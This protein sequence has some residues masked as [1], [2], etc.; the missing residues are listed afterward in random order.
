MSSAE[1]LIEAQ[2][3]SAFQVLV[4]QPDALFEALP[5]A[6]CLHAS[7]GAVVRF[8][9]KAAELWGRELRVGQKL[10][11]FCGSR[12]MSVRADKSAP[13]ERDALTH[14]LRTGQP[15][16]GGEIALERPDGYR[17]TC[18][19]DVQALKSAAGRIEGAL[20]CYRDSGIRK[21][22]ATAP[23]DELGRR[24]ERDLAQ[25]IAQQSALYEFTDRL[26]RSR[27]LDEVY[28]AALEAILRALG[29]DRASILLFDDAGVMRFVASRGL[30]ETY[31]RAVEGHS[32]WIPESTDPQPIVVADISETSEPESLKAVVRQEGIAGLS[33]IPLTAGGKLIGKFMTYYNGGHDFDDAE[34]TLA[35]I[36]ARQIGLNV[37]RVRAEE[38]RRVSEEALLRERELFQTIIDRIPVMISVYEPGGRLLQLN[39]EFERLVGWRIEDLPPGGSLMEAIYPDPKYRA[40]VMDFMNSCRDGWMDMEMRARDG[41]VIETTWANIRLSRGVQVGIGLDISER[42]RADAL[43]ST[44]LSDSQ[45]LAA[46]VE[47]S[48]DAIVSKDLNGIIVS[49]NQGAERLFGYTAEEVVG[50]PITILMPPDRVN[51]E[52]AILAR[53]RRGERVEH[54]ETI[55]RRKD[56]TQLDISLTI[57]PVKNGRGEIVGASK[58]ARNISDAKRMEEQRNLLIAELSHRVKNTLATVISIARQSFANPDAAEARLSFDSRIRGMAQTHSRLAE[59]SW[60]GVPL[61]TLLNDELAPY[62]REDGTN[63]KTSGPGVVLSA[64]AA[65]TLGMAIHELATNAAKYGALSNKKGKIDVS[66]SFVGNSLHIAWIETGGPEVRLPTRSGFGRM[67]IERALASDLHGDVKLEF[68]PSGLR[69]MISI[70]IE[71][72]VAG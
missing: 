12:S 10:D 14:A 36:I 65:L 8:N 72:N 43:R 68:P 4:N 64:R 38:A 42:A 57:S 69:C 56:G 26:Q 61:D 51:E 31:Q 71:C 15:T 1:A 2:G 30:S 18:G 23:Q 70:P 62:R 16:F 48:E 7:D 54:F 3:L 41:R 34:I 21:E 32:P 55:R 27:S 59:A 29:C 46:I 6:T 19:I 44:L 11:R 45:R 58:I 35:V 37:E 9:R 40:N 52:P 22:P 49:W 25:R 28:E 53:I 63:V 66:W 5:I 17:I 39:P 33:F 47:S 67:L 13:E 20:S 60:S 24:A 50:K